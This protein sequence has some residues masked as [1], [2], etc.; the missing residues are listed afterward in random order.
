MPPSS[1]ACILPGMM[2]TMIEQTLIL[3]KPDGVKRGLIGELIKRF[4]NRGLKLVGMKMAWAD[5]KLAGNHY[6]E[7]IEERYGKE[8]RNGL[9]EYL[10]EGPVIAMVLEGINAVEIV[11]KMIGSTYPHESPPGTIRG[12]F[13]HI[14]K[15][16]A[17]ENKK[18]VK[19]LVHASVSKEEAKLEKSL[20]FTKDEIYDYP[21]AEDEHVI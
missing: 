1:P 5:E 16:Y 11:R 4:E 15:D 9:L 14:S 6:R 12:D 13:A 2:H 21:R 10:K 17:N 8:V 3:I 20:W 18:N 19:N 7:D